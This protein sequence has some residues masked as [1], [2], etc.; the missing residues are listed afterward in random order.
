MKLS[1]M[2]C[3]LVLVMSPAIAF[4]AWVSTNTSKSNVKNPSGLH[5]NNPTRGTAAGPH[6][7]P[8]KHAGQST[9]DYKSRSNIN[10]N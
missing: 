1:T 6:K 8:P 5:L 2:V 7:A 10:N 9:S 3:A 4:A